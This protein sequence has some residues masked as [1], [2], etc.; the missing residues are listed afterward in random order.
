VA[1][2]ISVVNKFMY[3]KI[4]K[5]KKQ[6]IVILVIFHI[7]MFSTIFVLRNDSQNNEVKSDN[8]LKVITTIFPIYDMAR[9]IGGDKIELSQ[10]L[11]PG[12]EAHSFELKPSDIAKINEADIFIY[13]S[14]AMEPWIDDLIKSLNNKKLIIVDAGKNIKMIPGVNR[15]EDGVVSEMDPHI[16][17][18]FDNTQIMLRNVLN[19]IENNDLNNSIYYK[20]NFEDYKNKLSILD[21]K[22]KSSLSNCGSHKIVYGGHYAFAY[23]ASR[24]NLEYSAAQGFSPNSE[25]SVQDLV[26]LIKQIKE[27]ELDYIYYEELSSPK[28]SEMIAAE[29]DTKLLLLNAAH[30]LPKDEFISGISLLDIF[31]SNLDNLKLG[32]NCK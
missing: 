15:D 13:T 1:C 20:N 4:F 29:T 8:K 32:L 27:D 25:P 3:K 26:S 16:W 14:R 22:Y 23:L 18:D 11:P 5:N 17:L 12:I 10:L 24:Y 30:N 7:I 31:N 9:T 19:A 21:S 28:I 2:V 6:A